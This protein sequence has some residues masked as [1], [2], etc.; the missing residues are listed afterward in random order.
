M[1]NKK[2]LIIGNDNYLNAPTLGGCI[3]DSVSIE[4]LL[5]HNEDGTGNFSTRRKNDLS[6]YQMKDE[7]ESFLSR[8]SS[9]ALIYFSGHGYI[10][11]KGGFLC[12]IDARKGHAGISMNWL[13]ETINKC[14]IPEIAVILDCCHAGK[15]FDTEDKDVEFAL[16]KHGVTVLAATT[17]NDT[18][19][20]FCGKGVF[21]SILVEGLSGAAKDILGNVSVAGLYACAEKMLS[22]FQQRPV[23]K[24]FVEQITTIRKCT[25]L[26]SETDLRKIITSSFFPEIEA[27]ITVN[28]H[29]LNQENFQFD[30]S[31]ETY[32]MLS[33][34]EKAGLLECNQGKTLIQST[35]D[36]NWGEC[37]LSKYGKYIWRL[38]KNDQIN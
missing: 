34:Y 37:S 11:D 3:N 1:S 27:K 26:I 22:P 7:I 2:A 14:S 17:K 28:H 4:D 23:F 13:S 15:M 36:P 6:N 20:E 24:S 33:A 32:L 18:A 21:T 10:N 29:I 9:Y 30:I 25:P 19:A 8:K 12:G 35:L 16:I 38:V 5:K 31:L